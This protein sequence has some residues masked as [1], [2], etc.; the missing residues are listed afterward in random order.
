MIAARR[1][2]DRPAT[3]PPRRCPNPESPVTR[4][5]IE[6]RSNEEAPRVAGAGGLAGAPPS[7]WEAV[8]DAGLAGET[9]EAADDSRSPRGPEAKGP[10]EDD[11]LGPDPGLVVRA[12]PWRLSHLML[13][14]VVVAVILWLWINLRMLGVIL[15]PVGLIV[16]A[17]TSGF[18]TSRL[19]ASRQEALLS[20]LA[21]A[22]E[23]GVPLAPAIS[24]FA[25]QFRGRSQR[26]ILNV[27]AELNAGEPIH[28]ALSY[29]FR[30]VSRDALLMARIGDE[31]G[32]L[33]QA[34]RLVGSG[35]AA[36]VG[37]WGAMASRLTYLLVV[38]SVAEA[39]AGFQLYFIVPRFEAI[40][41]DFGVRLPAI[42]LFVIETSHWLVRYAWLA[43]PLL[44][45][46]VGLLLFLPFSFGGWM[47]Y[48]VPIFDRLMARRH[49]A[50]VLRA[51]SVVIEA[52][53]PIALGLD[54]MAE[55]YPARWVRRRLVKV[56]ADVRMGV[57]WID[58]LWRRGVIR[59]SD[60]EVLG[61][62]AS[63]G[64]LVWACRELAE[65]AER[66]QQL[67]MQ[68]LVQALFPLAVLALGAAI[69]TL[70][71]GYFVPLVTL[72]QKLSDL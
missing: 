62:A 5:P 44:L 38:V 21:I 48:Q 11:W 7:T 67:R 72:I 12:E 60:A 22:A 46:Q 43:F 52:G 17:I 65:T 54:I 19:R 63:V 56:S 53:K 23:R 33:A 71:L 68:V 35:R 9:W 24:A 15:T 50:L 27:V 10:A 2:T 45:A 4:E 55:Q 64:N 39:I 25:D 1:P 18:I 70:C 69:A 29:P 34:L 31:T 13:A 30:V 42:T 41:A 6:P 37:A 40:F 3:P 59:R 14:I 36:R 58:A 28:K 26:R 47:N 57:D 66:R 16:L 61:S 51:L 49:T 20:L 32:R 8:D